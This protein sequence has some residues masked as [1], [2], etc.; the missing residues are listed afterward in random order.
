MKDKD[1]KLLEEAYQKMQEGLIDKIRAGYAGAKANVGTHVKNLGQNIQ[2]AVQGF[3]SGSGKT[4]VNKNIQNPKEEQ[5]K[6]KI[7]YFVDDFIK[8]IQNSFNIKPGEEM[9]NLQTKLFS[10]LEEAIDKYTARPQSKV[11]PHGYNYSQPAT[12][13]VS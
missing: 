6:A 1:T 13:T 2:G 4:V 10:D 8:N 9:T 5:K 11:K 12:K 3:K 7:K